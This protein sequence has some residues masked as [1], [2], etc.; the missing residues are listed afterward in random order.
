MWLQ[1]SEQEN[2]QGSLLSVM[3]TEWFEQDSD[4]I[5]CTLIIA[6]AYS[7]CCVESR[8]QRS[9]N[10]SDLS[11]AY[12]TGPEML[13]AWLRC[14]VSDWCSWYFDNFMHVHVS[15]EVMRLCVY[16]CI[17]KFHWD[18]I[19]L[20]CCVSF[21]CTAKWFSSDEAFLKKLSMSLSPLLPCK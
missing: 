7:D 11:G 13:V 20:Q 2:T 8:L 5:W 12:G 14:K 1:Q 3:G 16:V 17:S 10:I 15:V 9:K 6:K 18:T 4:V 19:D 21:K